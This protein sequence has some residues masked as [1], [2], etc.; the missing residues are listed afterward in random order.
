MIDIDIP[1]RDHYRLEHLVLDVNG[2]LAL[3]GNLLDGVWT[4]FGGQ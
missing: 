4:L 1:G 2:T 3:D